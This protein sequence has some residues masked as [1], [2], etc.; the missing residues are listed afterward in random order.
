MKLDTLSMIPLVSTVQFLKCRSLFAATTSI[1]PQV[2][3]LFAIAYASNPQSSINRQDVT[4]DPFLLDEF[5]LLYVPRGLLTFAGF[6][7]I[8]LLFTFLAGILFPTGP[9]RFTLPRFPASPASRISYVASSEALI[10]VIKQNQNSDC[11]NKTSPACCL[12]GSQGDG[13]LRYKLRYDLWS[14]FPE[15]RRYLWPQRPIVD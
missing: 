3:D 14:S 5:L 1:L 11:I 15:P 12:A 2:G 6:F 8:Y 4:D 7:G 13:S 10:S 9:F